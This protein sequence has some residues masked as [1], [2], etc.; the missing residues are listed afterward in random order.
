MISLSTHQGTLHRAGAID[1][2]FAGNTN[3]EA[4]IKKTL[5]T[6]KKFTTEISD[7]AFRTYA[8]AK[9]FGASKEVWLLE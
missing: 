2:A 6:A 1:L 5:T 3:G 9:L 7:N 4:T 8:E